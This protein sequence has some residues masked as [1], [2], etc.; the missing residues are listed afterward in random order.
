MSGANAQAT[1]TLSLIDRVTGPI[2]RIANRLG[3]LSKRVGFDKITTAVGT[4]GTRIKELGEGLA[5][6]SLRLSAFFGLIGAGGA[7]LI[8]IA[9]G[10]AKS[11]S[12][13]GSEI[14]DTAG[15]LGIGVEALQEYRFA[16]RMSG[17]E[18]ATFDKG[19]EKLGINAVEATKG[20]KQ[21]A[22][23][24]KTLGVRV[25][26][27]KGKMRGVEDI[28]DATMAA[29]A[30][31]EDPIKRNQLAFKLFGKSGVEMVKMLADGAEG[32]RDQREEARRTGNVMGKSAIALSDKF[33]D[34]FDALSERVTGLKNLIGVQLIPVFMDAVDG[35]TKWYDANALL[36]RSNITEWV[37]NLGEFIRDLLNPTSEIRV[38]FSEFTGAIS[39]AYDAIKPF[40]DF[41][42]GPFKAAML[43]L[44][45]WAL[46]PA[47][48][49]VTLLGGAFLGLGKAVA[50]V[51]LNTIV[52]LSGAVA[53]AAGGGLAK[54]ME[55]AG[56]SAG[57]LYGKA[58]A[59]AARLAII[60]G[61]AAVTMELL[62]TYDPK[63]NLGGITKP[64]DD[65]LRN[66]LGLPEKDTGITP[67][68]IWDGFFG[69]KEGDKPEAKKSSATEAP[70]KE[71][72]SPVARD[73]GFDKSPIFGD[74]P[75]IQ[76][77]TSGRRYGVPAPAPAAAP[78]PVS[79]PATQAS[80]DPA[81]TTVTIPENMIVHE[82]KNTNV[83]VQIT[84]PI[85]ITAQ[86]NA[87]PA[88][89]GAAVRG[90]LNGIAK[91]AASEAGSRLSD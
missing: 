27:S 59:L 45:L 82:P 9:Y 61:I 22:A 58:F 54:A 80:A 26:D 51:A 57:G 2:K 42:G 88:T 52:G 71:P 76:S 81:K 78:P 68:E 10:M 40:V 72:L 75:G 91:R 34:A 3:A 90:E 14:G 33:G 56:S 41:V 79:A 50:G 83:T 39:A 17:M 4:L 44:G 15:K 62:Q 47:I 49:A 55:T 38:K 6:T 74:A 19:V 63:G 32:L 84:A 65:W 43:L 31:I 13:L 5:R 28:L 11:A 18:T 60:A 20:N 46:A 64:V 67:G 35:I 23:A 48:T 87:D 53:D 7:G 8:S 30:K 85:S 69:T 70:K 1:V 12:D 21:L 29:L 37:K 25:K 66:K 24:F 73:L 86:T 36:I 16:A 77:A 89:I